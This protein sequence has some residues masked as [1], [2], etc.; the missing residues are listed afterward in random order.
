MKKIKLAMIITTAVGIAYG[1]VLVMVN[2][3][4]VL[5]VEKSVFFFT[6]SNEFKLPFEVSM[7]WNLLFFPAIFIMITYVIRGRDEIIGREP[8]QNSTSTVQDNYHVK[9]IV[10][11]MTSVSMAFAVWMFMVYMILNL[12]G[13]REF[14]LGGPISEII[15]SFTVGIVVYSGLGFA[16]MFITT[17]FNNFDFDDERESFEK[18]NSFFFKFRKIGII[19]T[20]PFILALVSGLMCRL[21][22]LGIIFVIKKIILFLKPKKIACS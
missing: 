19:K 10:F 8:H 17:L 22:V 6:R 11:I 7:W 2:H 13:S 14:S 16:L 3:Y 20:L 18:Y 21:I 5:P 12:L 1:V 15:I 4:G 9:D